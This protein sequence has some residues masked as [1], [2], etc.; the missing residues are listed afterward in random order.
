MKLI[1]NAR[2]I[3]TQVYLV[4][5]I[6][7]G[8]RI[9]RPRSEITLNLNHNV[10]SN[11]LDSPL[12]RRTASCGYAN[13]YRNVAILMF[14]LCDF[15]DRAMHKDVDSSGCNQSRLLLVRS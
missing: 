5:M 11:L 12:L 13:N 1:F 8:S 2:I 3:A 7:A 15:Y 6:A 10:Y 4:F 9:V 14:C